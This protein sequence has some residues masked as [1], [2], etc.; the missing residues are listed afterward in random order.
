LARLHLPLGTRLLHR[1][2]RSLRRLLHR[3][4]RLSHTLSLLLLAGLTLALL[5]PLSLL[6]LPLTVLCILGRALLA[7]LRLFSSGIAGAVQSRIESIERSR[8]PHL[9]LRRSRS[10]GGRGILRLTGLSS[11]LSRSRL[12]LRARLTRLR[13]RCALLPLRLSLCRLSLGWCA[14]R[15]IPRL[16]PILWRLAALCSL[17]RRLPLGGLRLAGR[18]CLR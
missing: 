4:F 2:L 18:R 6:R 1:L 7:G 17:S 15:C 16:L 10:C 9:L 13:H 3:G 14:C 8:H 5:F 12:P 11:G